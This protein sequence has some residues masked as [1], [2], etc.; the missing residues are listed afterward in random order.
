MPTLN[1]NG[2]LMLSVKERGKNPWTG[3]CPGRPVVI[4]DAAYF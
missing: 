4:Q 3:V 1:L 2:G